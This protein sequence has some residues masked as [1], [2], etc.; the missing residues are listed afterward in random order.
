VS[1]LKSTSIVVTRLLA[2]NR[3]NELKIG[4]IERHFARLDALSNELI[5][6]SIISLEQSGN[7]G[8]LWE[9]R[10]KRTRKARLVCSTG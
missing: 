10:D 2:V 8:Q 6:G 3:V 1:V 9:Q 4:T 5:R 7:R